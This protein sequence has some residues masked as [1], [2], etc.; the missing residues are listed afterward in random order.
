[1]CSLYWRIWRET[2]KRQKDLPNLQAGKKDSSKRSNSSNTT[3]FS[4]FL[5]NTLP[6]GRIGR[7]TYAIIDIACT[8]IYLFNRC[9]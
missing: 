6:P 8:L 3:I 7:P 9:V 1:M 5:R 2:E 4:N